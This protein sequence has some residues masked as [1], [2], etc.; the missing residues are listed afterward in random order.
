MI[1]PTVFPE[2]NKLNTTEN[3]NFP[4]CWGDPGL[5]SR[6]TYG[7]REATGFKNACFVYAKRYFSKTCPCKCSFRLR[8]TQLSKNRSRLVYAK[9]NLF[10]KTTLSSTQNTT[11]PW[12]ISQTW[13][14]RRPSRAEQL[15]NIIR[16]VYAKQHFSKHGH[17]NY[18]KRYAK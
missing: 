4:L 1:L 2:F 15:Q 17:N 5:R 16:F 18:Q 8:E 7:N 10:L 14:P 9:H 3:H 6:R 12:L 13:A 11:F